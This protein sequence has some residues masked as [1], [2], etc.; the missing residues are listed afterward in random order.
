MK[1][2]LTIELGRLCPESTHQITT[3]DHLPHARSVSAHNLTFNGPFLEL[4]DNHLRM[5]DSSISVIE[6]PVKI[7]LLEYSSQGFKVG[8]GFGLA[9]GKSFEKLS[10]TVNKTHDSHRVSVFDDKEA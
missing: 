3:F 5:F 7:G 6:K 9:L 2:K 10:D 1:D 4:L 8:V